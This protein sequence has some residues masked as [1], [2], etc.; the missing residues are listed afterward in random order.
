[1]NDDNVVPL[2]PRRDA[3]A[4]E[5][6]RIGTREMLRAIARTVRELGEQGA[7]PRQIARSLRNAANDLDR[8]GDSSG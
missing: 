2:K 7:T 4:F 6:P 5:E 1:M 8:S 3:P